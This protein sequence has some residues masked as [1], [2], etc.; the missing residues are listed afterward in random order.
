V[1]IHHSAYRHGVSSEDIHHAVEHARVAFEMG[2]DAGPRR[3]LLI[4]PNRAGNF[5]E[6][7]A[8]QLEGGQHLAIHAMKLRPSFYELLEEDA[9]G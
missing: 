3:I 1:E 4:G 6:V 9:H 8:L 2:A 7:I 5:I